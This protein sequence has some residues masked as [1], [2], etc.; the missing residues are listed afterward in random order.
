L[1]AG[2]NAA[3]RASGSEPVA[4]DRT[5]SYIGVMVDD[6]VTRGVTEPYRMFT[7]RAEFRLSLRVDNADERLT[8]LGLKLGLVGA[9]RRE[10]F[11]ARTESVVRLRDLLSSLTLTPQQAESF[12]LQLNR[13]GL[14]RTA[15]QLLSYP[16]VS[17]ETLARIWPELSSFAP[18]IASRVTADAT[19]SV[20]LDRQAAEIQSYKRDQALAVPTDLD[21]DGISGLSNEL[22]AKLNEHRPGNLAQ[23]ARIEGMTPAALT[24][25]AAHARRGRR[26]PE[27][28][29]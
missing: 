27:P 1:L 28:A 7:S 25:L 6:L 14:K 5:A 21:L 24:L 4:L 12:G 18:A 11:E 29:V 23:A 8:P 19:Y 10:S 15:F 16:D 13:D 26:A 3:C 17:L 9:C 22:K 20:Y 2:L